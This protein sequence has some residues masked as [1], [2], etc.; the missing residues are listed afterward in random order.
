MKRI[1]ELFFAFITSFLLCSIILPFAIKRLSLMS[2]SQSIRSCGPQSHHIK[3]GTPTMGGLIVLFS[4]AISVF[5]WANLCNVFI[6][7]VCFVTYSFGFI[8]WID[9]YYKVKYRTSE[10]LRARVKFLWLLFFSVIASLCIFVSFDLYNDS[11]LSLR[12]IEITELF[13][14]LLSINLFLFV[15]LI[16]DFSYV[17]GIFG[18]V[19]LSCFVIVG[20]SNAVNLTDGLD[21]LA[22]F[23]IIVVA[24]SLGLFAYVVGD[25]H[26]I[27]YSS[28]PYI[29]GARDLLIFCAAMAGSGLS[30]LWFNM[31]PASIFMGDVGSLALGGALGSIAVITRQEVNLIIIGGI[32]VAETISVILQVFWFKYTK[33]KYGVGRRIFRM[34]P[35]HHHFEISGWS[36]VQVVIRFWIVNIILAVI[37]LA[38]L[39]VN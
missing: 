15:P 13:S 26:R 14:E 22:I 25:I 3:N 21:G 34:T 10:G 32:F 38:T 5:L 30:F 33:R 19:F 16:G 6:W 20:T 7:I 36:E 1:L 4:I 23:P 17:F 37:S 39:C 8:G 27:N 35:L 12:Q 18:F 28:L 29:P 31:H 24:S 9:D 2:I 11:L